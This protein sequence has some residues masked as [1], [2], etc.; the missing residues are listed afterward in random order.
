MCFPRIASCLG[1]VLA[2]GL[3]LAQSG[4]AVAAY[5]LT[6]GI[7]TGADEDIQEKAPADTGGG[8]AFLE[9]RSGNISG[10]ERHLTDFFRFDFTGVSGPI[11]AASLKFWIA[12]SRVDADSFAID[13]YG[14]VDGVAGENDWTASALS[15][16]NAP[17]LAAADYPNIDRDL[18]AG[19]FVYLGAVT[20]AGGNK[21]GGLTFS[22]QALLDF[23]NADTNHAVTLFLEPQVA[24]S[25][26]DFFVHVR[27]F[28]G[29]GSDAG[30]FAP[31]LELP[32]VTPPGTSAPPPTNAVFLTDASGEVTAGNGIVRGIFSKTTGECRD[33]RFEGGAN[34]LLNGGRLYLDSNSGGAYYAFG[35]AVYSLVENTGQRLHF[36]VVGRMGE[37]TT[38]LHYV[39][40]VG[41]AGFHC[42][43]VFR[44]GAG[45]AATY[46]E[47]ARMVLRCDKNV[48]TSAF[49]S[50]QKTGQMIAPALLLG[51]PEI[52]DATL[53]LPA[54]SS[55][56][57]PTGLT[58][59]G[60]PVYTKYDWADFVETHKA[61][62]LAGDSTG[63]WLISGSE[64]CINGGPTKSE[65]F[66]HGTDTTPLM[67][68]TFHAAHFIGSDSNLQL[69]AGEVWEK[70]Y[71]PYFI[72]LNAG[73][74]A[75]ALWQDALV[76]A[77]TEKAAW[78]LGGL[79]EAA[80]PVARGTVSGRLLAAGAAGANA[81][82]V[83]AQP[84]S[85]WQAQGRGY[86]FWTRA[87]A[88][89]NFTIPKVRPGAYSLYAC[90]PGFSGQMELGQV[91]VGASATTDLGRLSWTPPRRAQTLWQIGT[92]DRSTAEFRFGDRMRQFGLWWR[93][94]EEK[95]TADLNYTVGASAPADWYYA[96]SVMALDNGSYL[97]PKWNVNF[98]LAAIPAGPAELVIDFAGTMSSTLNLTLNGT[99]LGSLATVND[100]G[101][102]RSA[103]S[104]SRYTQKRVSISTS[105]LRTGTN[106]LSFQLSGHSNWS[107][108]KPVSPASGVMYDAI[109]LEAGAATAESLVRDYALTVSAGVGGTVSGGGYF[110]SGTTT[111]I[112]ASASAGYRFASWN[113][114]STVA[115][116]NVTVN[117]TAAYAATF[118]LTPQGAFDQWAASVLPAGNRTFAGDADGNGIANGIEFVYGSLA[119][120]ATL[121]EARVI[122]GVPTA[123]LSAA[124]TA[125]G[126]AYTTL[127]VQATNDLL[128][129]TAGAV[130]LTETQVSGERRWTP[131]TAGAKVYFRAVVRLNP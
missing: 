70:L 33:L 98:T 39:L 131:A 81:L 77:D 6:T 67:I 9:L 129:W 1:V 57:T 4:S 21:S 64:E 95:G 62:G 32:N 29:V 3:W 61:H 105:L 107:G 108:T 42:Y 79:N 91:T 31:T 28:E 74:G 52:M 119:G 104:L 102:Y 106:T 37:L 2:C 63:L 121:L 19:E 126:T 124:P 54:S 15:Y 78:P 109:R 58:D 5:S 115:A 13:V 49:S 55:Y 99:S 117:G 90:V 27:A 75:Q 103:T 94:L 38:E 125:N 84:G 76:R 83:L 44:H 122:G 43:T 80:Y 24:A 17:G 73:A 14:V 41:D 110:T 60:L 47:Q 66:I 23:I 72:Y 100:A 120:A 68:A 22:N 8:R 82:M 88:A 127:E 71:G 112:Q 114:G 45:D 50:E 34:L 59:A 36:K 25:G 87:D 40:E 128:D 111:Q 51:A 65:L 101:I 56:T 12:S 30:D 92:P 46:L 10:S 69:A 116:R 89:G 18:A 16:N 85:D 86:L 118:V 97:T 130:A 20:Y 11:N 26:Q 96:Q 93:Y 48:F 53:Q 123:V 7:G 35:S 113:D